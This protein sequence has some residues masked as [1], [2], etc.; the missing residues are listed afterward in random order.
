LWR[1]TLARLAP[2]LR[3]TLSRKEGGEVQTLRTIPFYRRGYQVPTA[4]MM[5]MVMHERQAVNAV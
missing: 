2:L 1:D 3:A 4:I 5:A